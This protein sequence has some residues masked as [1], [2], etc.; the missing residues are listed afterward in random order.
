MVSPAAPVVP[1]V[2]WREACANVDRDDYSMGGM[3]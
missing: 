3:G 1:E 2:W